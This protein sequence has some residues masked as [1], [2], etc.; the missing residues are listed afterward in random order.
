MKFYLNSAILNN[1]DYVFLKEFMMKKLLLIGTALLS[2]ASYASDIISQ[3]SPT[4]DLV[5]SL[6][7]FINSVQ[8]DTETNLISDKD[9]TEFSN[10]STSLHSIT[11]NKALNNNINSNR[12]NLHQRLT[13]SIVNKLM[14]L[15]QDIFDN[16][17]SL[18]KFNKLITKLE[19]DYWKYTKMFNILLPLF[20]E[21]ILTSM[22]K[23]KGIRAE[24]NKIYHALSCYNLEESSSKIH[25]RQQYSLVIKQS[26]NTINK[27][28]SL[29]HFLVIHDFFQYSPIEQDEITEN[30][31]SLIK[32]ASLS[33]QLLNW[34]SKHPELHLDF[35]RFFY[36]TST[37]FLKPKIIFQNQ[38]Y[39]Y[40]RNFP[41]ADILIE[42][43]YSLERGFKRQAIEIILP[44]LK[45]NFNRI[46]NT[47]I[48][49]NLIKKSIDYTINTLQDFKILQDIRRNI[50]EAPFAYKYIDTLLYS[51]DNKEPIINMIYRK[52]KESLDDHNKKLFE[53]L[54]KLSESIINAYNLKKI[55]QNITNYTQS[56]D[57]QIPDFVEQ[58]IFSPLQKNCKVEY[59]DNNLSS[60]EIY[61]IIETETLNKRIPNIETAI[62]KI[63]NTLQFYQEKNKKEQDKEQ[64]IISN[65]QLELY[66]KNINKL[67]INLMNLRNQKIRLEKICNI[68][69]KK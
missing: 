3:P 41:W 20:K 67:E 30:F 11:E 48:A 5:D 17:V 57:K 9:I 64:K 32:L 49:P 26:L 40:Y 68:I 34:L 63:K 60:I 2:A 25:S 10:T 19:N 51:S 23:D 38:L 45:H 7:N 28:F 47:P 69:E 12:Q 21:D 53:E 58:D 65:I 13:F 59:Y 62:K 46:S 61:V 50:I 31:K 6:P 27:F 24:F 55:I 18:T 37:F 52:K 43:L 1:I 22:L 42:P 66:Q 14:C 4:I 36:E 8:S 44:C 54:G 35:D 16:T 29:I 56:P 33:K 39:D 15:E